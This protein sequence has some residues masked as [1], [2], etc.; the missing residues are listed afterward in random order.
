MSRD[1]SVEILQQ[2]QPLVDLPRRRTSIQMRSS[3]VVADYKI[4]GIVI[5]L[6]STFLHDAKSCSPEDLEWWSDPCDNVRNVR[7]DKGDSQLLTQLSNAINH[8]ENDIPQLTQLITA[9]GTIYIVHEKFYFIPLRKS[10]QLPFFIYYRKGRVR[11][12]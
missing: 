8:L 6:V 12:Q 11:I 5:L 7:H 9:V 3:P 10:L 4:I 1:D 2:Q